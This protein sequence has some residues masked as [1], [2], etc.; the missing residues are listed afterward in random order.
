MNIKK[1]VQ[2]DRVIVDSLIKNDALYHT[3]EL[4][5]FSAI[6]RLNSLIKSEALYRTRE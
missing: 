3:T 4:E 2:N 5:I 6:M 1:S